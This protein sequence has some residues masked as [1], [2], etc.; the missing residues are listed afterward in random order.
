MLGSISKFVGRRLGEVVVPLCTV[1][2]GVLCTGVAKA[3]H[4]H[5][6]RKKTLTSWSESS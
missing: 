2:P 4:T 5:T 6:H 3:R 1:H